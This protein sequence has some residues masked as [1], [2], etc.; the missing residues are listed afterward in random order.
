[1]H[2]QNIYEDD[3][4]KDRMNITGSCELPQFNVIVI[5]ECENQSISD[6]VFQAAPQPSGNKNKTTNDPIKF[7][8]VLPSKRAKPAWQVNP[9]NFFLSG[10]ADDNAQRD[11]GIDL[12]AELTARKYC[13]YVQ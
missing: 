7:L 6:C 8:P 5:A 13:L 2:E 10:N 11:N 3:C 12:V 4:A 9:P 1:M